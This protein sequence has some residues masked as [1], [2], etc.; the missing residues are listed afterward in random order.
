VYP[1]RVAW[2]DDGSLHA[3][4]VLSDPFADR[5]WGLLRCTLR[6][7]RCTR[8]RLPTGATAAAIDVHLPL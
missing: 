5:S 6:P 8:Q 1:T 7:A 3:A 2:A 4:V